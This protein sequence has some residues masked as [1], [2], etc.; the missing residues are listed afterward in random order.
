M[1]PRVRDYEFGL[2]EDEVVIEQDVHVDQARAVA[3]GLLAAQV[4]LELF[5]KDDQRKRCSV[6]F[7]GKCHVEEGG[8]VGVAPRW[9]P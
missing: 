9:V 2:F 7:A 1:Q 3:E 6:G 5:Q 4:G 8:L